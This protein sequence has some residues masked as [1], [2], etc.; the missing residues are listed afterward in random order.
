MKD[1][2]T[3]GPKA[4]GELVQSRRKLLLVGSQDKESRR[5]DREGAELH[6]GGPQIDSP[7]TKDVLERDASY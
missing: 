1:D 5:K 4:V 6:V 3:D 2:H 7:I